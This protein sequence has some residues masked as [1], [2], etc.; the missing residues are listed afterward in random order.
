MDPTTPTDPTRRP[1]RV[2]RLPAHPFASHAIERMTLAGLR[3]TRV[4]PS[5]VTEARRALSRRDWRPWSEQPDLDAAASRPSRGPLPRYRTA[6][7]EARRNA[8]LLA[9]AV[10]L[11]AVAWHLAVVG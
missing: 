9:L 5:A 11:L 4:R 2:V 6:W 10:A 3:L 8:L 1:R 7:Q